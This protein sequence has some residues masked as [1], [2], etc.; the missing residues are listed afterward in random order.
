MTGF[1]P[2]LRAILATAAFLAQIY[3]TYLCMYLAPTR[4]LRT[5]GAIYW[6]LLFRH[7]PS[8]PTDV[9]EIGVMAKLRSY[10]Q[11]MVAR[12]WPRADNLIAGLVSSGSWQADRASSGQMEA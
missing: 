12:A 3:V 10:R 8:R 6:Y 4:R 7:G 9:V 1:A 5:W 11:T 2:A